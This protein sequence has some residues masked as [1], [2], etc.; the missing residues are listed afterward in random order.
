MGTPHKWKARISRRSLVDSFATARLLLCRK[1]WGGRSSKLG[2]VFIRTV[3]VGP[4]TY[5]A[6]SIAHDKPAVKYNFSPNY[7]A[8]IRLIYTIYHPFLIFLLHLQSLCVWGD[9]KKAT[10]CSRPYLLGGGGARASVDI[11]NEVQWCTHMVWLFGGTIRRYGCIRCSRYAA[12]YSAAH[13]W[14]HFNELEAVVYNRR[15]QYSEQR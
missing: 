5:A 8:R 10:P 3:R 7:R 14:K 15:T 12:V 1:T 11:E 2:I 13:S 6:Y 9:R 4:T